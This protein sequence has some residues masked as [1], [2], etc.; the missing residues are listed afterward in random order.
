[1]K[2]KREGLFSKYFNLSFS[3]VKMKMT[4][5]MLKTIFL[6]S[7]LLFQEMESE[8][9]LAKKNIFVAYSL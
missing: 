5:K 2:L 4:I 3:Q 7:V 8:W 9:K 6:F 1:M